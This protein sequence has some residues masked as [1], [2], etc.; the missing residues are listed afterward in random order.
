MEYMQREL[1]GDLGEFESAKLREHI[2]HCPDCAAMYERLKRLSAE[3][4]NLPKVTPPFSLVDAILPKL[5]EIDRAASTVRP[6]AGAP[7]PA[8][9]SGSAPRT[10][11]RRR[12]SRFNL[13]VLSGVIAAGVVAGIFLVTYDRDL[14]ND[15]MSGN[16]ASV[17]S[18]SS[19]SSGPVLMM[20]S[21][22]DSAEVQVQSG[23][24]MEKSVNF[25]KVV[26]QSSKTS[27][28]GTSSPGSARD[29][30]SG[31]TDGGG[32][33]AGAGTGSFPGS[34]PDPD[35]GSGSGEPLERVASPDAAQGGSADGV[36]VVTGSE[37]AP[38]DRLGVGA[39]P[40]IAGF[41]EE[42]AADPVESVSPDGSYVA[43]FADSRV[44][45][46]DRDG[47]ARF[48]GEERRGA[49]AAMGWTDDGAYFR[50]E[51]RREDGTGEIY[52]IDPAAGTETPEPQ[53]PQAPLAD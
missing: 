39:Q 47:N 43:V 41:L 22:A 38:A 46:Y 52:R 4:E 15:A 42:P 25:G 44:V 18:A 21:T 24:I 26:D 49:I 28:S 8:D 5:D 27:E 36:V 29:A 35:A 7:E 51:V 37:E 32:T 13:R 40:G 31:G 14:L 12:N 9:A 53:E 34:G 23:P 20:G 17:D 50:Y 33:D 3:L 10:A 1:D 48:E 6:G 11:P 45:I 19:G 30:R 16:S 2:R